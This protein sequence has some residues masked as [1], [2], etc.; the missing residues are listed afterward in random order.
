MKR[1]F[2]ILILAMCALFSAAPLMAKI[3]VGKWVL[4]EIDGKPTPSFTSVKIIEANGTFTVLW[5]YDNLQTFTVLNQ[6]TLSE[7]LPGVCVE[8][9][10]LAKNG[11]NAISFERKGNTLNLRYTYKNQ[12]RKVI[13]EKYIKYETYLKQH[14][15]KIRFG[16]F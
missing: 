2:S 12:P 16:Y 8:N 1:L 6:G 3:P 9:P 10:T 15:Q 7:Q 14:P 13:T 11:P 5:A 4:V